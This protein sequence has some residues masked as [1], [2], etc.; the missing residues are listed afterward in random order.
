VTTTGNLTVASTGA[1]DL[2][3]IIVGGNLFAVS[4]INS[5]SQTG[6]VTVAGTNSL[7]SGTSIDDTDM[8]FSADSA[9]KMYVGFAM[10]EN[11]GGIN[12]LDFMGMPKS[13]STTQMSTAIAG[14]GSEVVSELAPINMAQHVQIVLLT[15]ASIGVNGLIRVFIS[16]VNLARLNDIEIPLGDQLEIVG[17][18]SSDI[19]VTLPEK[20][21]AL[22]SWLRFDAKNNTLIVSS[23]PPGALP[24][25]VMLS[26]NSLRY[27]IVIMDSDIFRTKR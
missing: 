5:I 8:S 12:R 27:L 22:P 24:L 1:L 23:V 6:V 20:E 16:T 10:K 15:K 2:G 26:L 11:S 17:N 7:G 19:Q 21:E 9:G 14:S 25:E 18:G 13:I 4:R 3:M